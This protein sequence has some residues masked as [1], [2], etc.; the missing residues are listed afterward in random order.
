[1]N[2]NESDFK[3]STLLA[4]FAARWKDGSAYVDAWETLV[5]LL[6]SMV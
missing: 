3:V 6:W 5:E 2:R 1:M 4:S